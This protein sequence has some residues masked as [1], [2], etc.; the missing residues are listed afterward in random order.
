MSPALVRLLDT[1]RQRPLTDDEFETM[2]DV[3]V[4]DMLCTYWEHAV[5]PCARCGVARDLHRQWRVFAQ[6][7]ADLADHPFTP[8]TA[9]T[10]APEDR[11]RIP[12][13][14]PVPATATAPTAPAVPAT[15]TAP[16]APAAPAAPTTATAPTGAAAPGAVPAAVGAPG[17]MAATTVQVRVW[18]RR[19][20]LRRNPS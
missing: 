4:L 2:K 7:Q 19:L 14:A 17:P 16:T 20:F 12:V 11:G 15:A 9:P 6:D 18:R 1:A 10:R 3:A 5:E 8:L 13:E